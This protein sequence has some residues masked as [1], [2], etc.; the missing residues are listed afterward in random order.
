[1]NNIFLII[2]L[3]IIFIL[4]ISVSGKEKI[5]PWNVTKCYED[6]KILRSY[7]NFW[8]GNTTTPFNDTSINFDT[9]GCMEKCQV[10]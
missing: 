2:I 4:Y 1:M 10:Y 5:K 7:Q 8:R 3:I 9:I 6:C